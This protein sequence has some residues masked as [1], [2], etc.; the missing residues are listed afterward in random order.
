MA[1]RRYSNSKKKK[2]RHGKKSRNSRH[3]RHSRHSKRHS[4]RRHHHTRRRGRTHRGGS[5]SVCQNG[6]VQQPIGSCMN[7]TSAGGQMKVYNSAGGRA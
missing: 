1:K 4:G 2:S 7:V 3:S 5:V 6:G